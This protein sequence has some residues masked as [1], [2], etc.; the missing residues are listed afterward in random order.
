MVSIV[1]KWTI[2]QGCERKAIAA[3]KQLAKSVEAEKGTLMYLVHTPDPISFACVNGDAHE[4]LPPPCS[5]EVIFFEQYADQDA[6][7]Q[8]VNGQAFQS[9]VKEYGNLFVNSDGKPFVTI[10]FLK[11]RAGFIRADA[12]TKA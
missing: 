8:H 12:Q 11:R 5:R 10:E 6:F 3:L 2:R 7:C 1:V 9:F 4:S